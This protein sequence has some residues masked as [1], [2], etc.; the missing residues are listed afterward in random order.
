[1]RN[2]RI[3]TRLALGFGLVIILMLAMSGFSGYRML[4]SKD[5]NVIVERRQAV[6]ITALRLEAL[7]KENITRTLA[8]AK[9][10]DANI[11]ANF[12]KAMSTSKDETA[13]QMRRLESEIRDPSAQEILQKV[14]SLREAF[15]QGRDAAFKN[16]ENGNAS[17]AEAFFNREMPKIAANYVAQIEA[18]STYETQLVDSTFQENNSAIDT[19]VM[20]LSIA[21]LLALL[22]SPWFAWRV[23]RS[24][25]GP[26]SAAVGLAATVAR[27]NL[28]VDILPQGKDE[29]T[30]LERSLHDMVIGLHDAV[31][32]VRE[33]ADAIAS[34]AGQI[35]AGNTDLASRTEQ[36]S[37]S[38]TETAASMEEIT[39][40]VRQNTDNAQQAYELTAKATNSANDGGATVAKLVGAMS[41][42]HTKSR[43]MAE[44]V[45]VID[46]IAFQTN[47]L[48]LNA[49]VEAARAGEQGR[50]FAVVASEVRAL[51]QRSAASA[52]EIKSLI[53]A[54]V[55]LIT[56]GNE[57]ASQAGTSMQ[58]IV[59]DIG[60]V[61]DIMG[62][63]SSSS[64][65]QTSGIEQINVA[66]TQM[67][68]VTRQN[69]SLVEESAA[70]ATSLQEQAHTLA[71]L[72]A[73]FDLGQQEGQRSTTVDVREITHIP[74]LPEKALNPTVRRVL[75]K[76]QPGTRTQSSTRPAL[77][78][79]AQR[80][81]PQSA[82]WAEF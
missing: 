59:S 38:L 76:E 72:V 53:D 74:S 34:A 3:S 22:F 56:Q 19:A 29:I 63:I 37:A 48:A 17:Q 28:S 9:L 54:A 57:E 55:V 2:F 62:E 24:I 64:Q 39:S 73:T 81:A 66:V 51:A 50:G 7:V 49:A 41:D 80:V 52:K 15:L 44:I 33:G 70:A 35:T 1:M 46:S 60:H 6:N 31:G 82:E 40:T 47:I 5:D 13:E 68:D 18:L 36:Q 21:T 69:A 75:H 43:Q 20:I 71:E 67:D 45:G 32:Q 25:T 78:A 26:L 27:R 23:T 79:P 30:E 4:D 12:E 10:K 14:G 8:A 16:F 65:E 58:G 42:I 61:K 77:S 11:E